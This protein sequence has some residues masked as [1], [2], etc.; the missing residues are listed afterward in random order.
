LEE[1]VVVEA[2]R[3]FLEFSNVPKLNY[4]NLNPKAL[5]HH[6]GAKK[7]HQ[8]ITSRGSSE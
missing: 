6:P 4:R 3:G 5:Q 7:I 8:K 1:E 2:I